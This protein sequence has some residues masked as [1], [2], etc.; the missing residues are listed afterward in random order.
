M[1]FAWPSVGRGVADFL[2]LMTMTGCIALL[3]I[4]T[5]HKST[6]ALSGFGDYALLIILFVPFASGYAMVH[7]HY[8]ITDWFELE[9]HASISGCMND[10]IVF[11]A[12]KY[13]VKVFP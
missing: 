9:L 4:R 6:R 1:G 13:Y 7:P 2:T 10:L 11:R 12:A 8:L 5:F 3:G